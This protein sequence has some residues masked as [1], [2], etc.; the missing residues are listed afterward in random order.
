MSGQHIQHSTQM[1]R[2]MLASTVQFSTNNQ[3]P[4]PPAPPTRTTVEGSE[5][6]DGPDETTFPTPHT[7]TP[8]PLP[9]DP[10]ACLRPA[11]RTRTTFHTPAPEGTTAVLAARPA[12]AGRTGQRSTL[13]HH[14]R[15][16]RP[17]TI[18][19]PFTS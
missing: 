13:E 19:G 4:P 1:S 17:T 9:Q 18:G 10:T 15:N 12:S 11:P 8:G 5:T 16:R 14:P 6:R 2:K 3:P 7:G